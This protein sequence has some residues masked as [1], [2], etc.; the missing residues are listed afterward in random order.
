MLRF[1]AREMADSREL[2]PHLLE[3]L[4]GRGFRSRRRVVIPLLTTDPE[5]VPRAALLTVGEVRA[6]STRKLLVAVRGKSRTAANLIRRRG[7]TLLLLDTG[8][9]ISIQ[10]RAGRGRPCRSDLER[11]IF[12]LTVL[13]VS[14]DRADPREGRVTLAE[15]PRFGGPD[16]ARLFSAALFEELGGARSAP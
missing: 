7:A 6:H 16:A 14:T 9:A 12:P 5:G 13:R 1:E 10:A 15:G 11:Q 3:F 2:P 8:Q 4:A